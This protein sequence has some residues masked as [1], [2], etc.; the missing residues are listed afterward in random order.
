MKI[1]KSY[2]FRVNKR[3][4]LFGILA[5][6]L[7]ASLIYLVSEYQETLLPN[8]LHPTQEVKSSDRILI[9]APHPDDES[10]G[11]GGLIAKAVEKNATVMVVMVTDGSRSHTHG[12]YSELLA[13]FNLTNKTS[14]PELRHNETLNA[15][16]N[17]GLSEN[18]VIFLGYPDAGLKPMFETY[19][20]Y[21]K[22]YNSNS[23]FNP[24]DH[25]PYSF[26]YEKNA[27]YA[28]ANVVKNMETIIRDFKPNVVVYPDDGDDHP[29]HWATSAFVRYSLMELNSTV[30]EYT[31]LVHK[32]SK[33][34]SPE[35]YLPNSKLNP[36]S[37]LL[38]LDATWTYFS[39]N[40]NEENK[41]EN[42]I[43]SHE[44]QVEIK[45]NYFESFIRIN[46]LLAVYP[47]IAIARNNGEISMGI[48]PTSSFK[49]ELADASNTIFNPVSDLNSAG[50]SYDDLY[51]YL[52]MQTAKDINNSM[53]K[54]FHLRFFTGNETKRIDITVKNGVAEYKQEASNS[55]K[56]SENPV[57]ET[58]NDIMIVKLPKSIFSGATKAMMNVDIYDENT[59]KQVDVMAWRNFDFLSGQF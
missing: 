50:A 5:V 2:K 52:F 49:D 25:S 45:P 19:W 51:L 41:K 6:A 23:D 35:Y 38:D 15:I 28:G 17:L 42:A 22:T 13:K 20:D 59:G 33:W 10:L 40:E 32:G 44:S 47:D 12:G 1:G 24:Y 34:P 11:T 57:V 21:N 16:K 31:Y 39:L 3:M 46:D 54:N 9:F 55:I 26:S 53:I 37:G 29:D 18:N 56:P 4:L 48:L 7:F 58:K 30:Q 36:P 14:L 27:P 8:Y 43:N